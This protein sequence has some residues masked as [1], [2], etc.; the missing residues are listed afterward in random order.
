MALMTKKI[1]DSGFQFFTLNTLRNV[2][3]INKESTFFGI[4]SR[5]V[6]NQVLEKVEKDKYLV[7][8]TKLNDFSLANLVYQPSYVSFESALNFYGILSQFPYEISSGTPKKTA[9]KLIKE[10]TFTYVHLQKSLF[11]GYEKKD[12][13]LIALAEKALL[14]QLYLAAKGQKKVSLEEYDLSQIDQSR[15]QNFLKNYPRT[16]QFGN[17]I[18]LIKRYLK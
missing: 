3:E 4:I 11:W 15:F 13:F 14:D 6:K 9:K 10:K 7:A 1:Y 16:R 2:L 8:G 5:L 12:N 17:M 18:K